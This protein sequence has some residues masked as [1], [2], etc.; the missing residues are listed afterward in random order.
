M[1]PYESYYLK[2]AGNGVT[3]YTGIRYQKGNGFFGRLISG[4]ALPLLKYFGRQGIEAVGNVVS[5]IKENPEAKLSD[6]IKK[7]AKS[8]LSK[9]TDDGAKRAKKF[10]QTGK[11]VKKYKR[12]DSTKKTV[13]KSTK[14]NKSA[15][16][17]PKKKK[18][19][20]KS[21]SFLK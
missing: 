6:I 19:K 4:F 8:S 15:V 3:T 11:G 9:M 16:V 18:R 20:C 7:Q 13:I 21:E 12:K 2:Q 1:N 10:I 5:D 17:K 14:K